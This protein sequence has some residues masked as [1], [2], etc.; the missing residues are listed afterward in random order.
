MR[1][2]FALHLSVEGIALDKRTPEGWLRLGQ[3]AFTSETL[4]ADLAALRMQGIAAA[5]TE[6]GFATKVVIP[7]DQ[8]K[9]MTLADDTATEASVGAA[10]E[11]ATPY[12]MDELRF[13]WQVGGGSTRIAAVA[14]ETLAEAEA[15]A[16]EHRFEPIAF[17]ALPDAGWGGTEAF[18][19]AATAAEGR[20]LRRDPVP[21]LQVEEQPSVDTTADAEN[22]PAAAAAEEAGPAAPTHDASSVSEAEPTALDTP[23]HAS[24]PAAPEEAET[25]PLEP[26]AKAA[27]D[28]DADAEPEA[29]PV[30]D[31]TEPVPEP[32]PQFEA[33][34]ETEAEPEAKAEPEAEAEPDGEADEAPATI[35]V[36]PATPAPPSPTGPRVPPTSQDS[37]PGADDMAAS[38][39]PGA[40]DGDVASAAG[41]FFSSRRGNRAPSV[42][43]PARP[44][45]G[46]A[47]SPVVTPPKPVDPFPLP[48]G[49][50]RPKAPAKAPARSATRA[51][52]AGPPVAVKAQAPA[53]AAAPKTAKPKAAATGGSAAGAT[54]VAER[55]PARLAL[56]LTIVLLLM[57]GA[58]AA[59]AT[60]IAPAT[61]AAWFERAPRALPAAVPDDPAEAVVT[62]APVERVPPAPRPEA[63]VLTDLPPEAGPPMPEAPAVVTEA[64]DPNAPAVPE[65]D[66]ALARFY[67]AQGIWYR[68][69][70]GPRAGP[71]TTT[72]IA[73]P[74]LDRITPQG[75]AVALP[76]FAA[77]L[78]DARPSSHPLPPG[79][80]VRFRIGPDGLVIATPEGA[81]A[82]G[83][84]TV[85]AGRPA[86][87]P[88]AR[89]RSGAA[90]L[91]AARLIAF[92]PRA[93]P[94]GF[95]DKRERQQY[96]GYLREELAAFRPL[97]RPKS[98]RE[99]EE[100][101]LAA[102]PPDET[103]EAPSS[104]QAVAAS[105]RPDRRP[106]GFEQKVA[107]ARAA[108]AEA[109]KPVPVAAI[110]PRTTRPS[111]PTRQTVA[112]AA[113]VDDAINLRRV[114]L[115][116]VYGKPNAR[117]ALVRLGNGRFVRVQVG[118]RLD[119][120]R[121]QA[122][123]GNALR[124][125]KGGRNIVLQIP[126]T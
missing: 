6:G 36:V 49:I 43:A 12:R 82:P 83:G 33:E 118:G 1:P 110:A 8:I 51:P 4:K 14:Q 25:A 108:A 2:D 74:A 124:Y 77:L 32:E 64:P 79:P 69:P 66:P 115:I 59:F 46:A 58:V 38:L 89:D 10:L 104:E 119:G 23:P 26:S 30:E 54:A 73:V 40:A 61:F 95:A 72:D 71:L 96:G 35:A 13:D 90:T 37:L 11:G 28:R 18:F 70:D 63:D 9:F 48:E 52:V 21:Y 81:L 67:A 109:A 57:L 3:V 16:L 113:T 50:A 88:P 92:R 62:I 103:V 68:A 123:S 80:D 112:R 98:A 22:E 87:L 17:C 78:T 39:R 93:R 107:A 99:V 126:T 75:D 125:T 15:F 117:R 56:I 121:V 105:V 5:E 86:L 41:G 60:V 85:V 7:N 94:E 45:P 44:A 34:P 42:K 116:G 47:P 84:Y 101:R 106:K 102:L 53:P 20:E 24:E 122:I 65:D 31:V 120:G 111:G 114:N 76:T 97:V 27:I 100:E 19:G 91:D 55:K 29:P